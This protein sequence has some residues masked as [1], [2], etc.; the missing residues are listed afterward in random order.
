[1]IRKSLTWNV[2][3]VCSMIQ[4]GS[5]TFDNP[6]QRAGE[7]WSEENK[8]LLIHSLVNMFVPEIYALQVKSDSGNTYDIID[9]KQRL[10]IISSFIKDEWTL[11]E[12]P[13]IK[14]ETGECFDISNKKFS[15]LPEEIQDEIKGFSLSFKIIEL[16]ED[17]DE[18]NL[19]DDIFLRLNNGKPMSK[20]HLTLIS[21]PKNIQEFVRT[22]IKNNP[23]FNGVSSF[24]TNAIKKSDREM[25]IL[26]SVLISCNKPFKSFS[27]KDVTEFFKDNIV[28]EETLD[29]V[30]SAFIEIAEAFEH[31]PSKFCN[32]INI[33]SLVSLLNHCGGS[34]DCTEKVQKFIKFYSN[35]SKPA[36][37]YRK[38]CGAGSVKKENV[39][40]RIKGLIN[41]MEEYKNEK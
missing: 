21:M 35:N 3:Q 13:K 20:E 38:H 34:A 6:V 36:D 10:T 32:K 26:Q 28:E 1:M 17:D 24:T 9:G 29:R 40:N 23:L 39:I 41:M 33:P 2:K 11:T 5:I 12:T 30:T 22:Q 18:E 4:K 16:E 19:V 7:Q 25:A 15:E 27:S 37:Q 31:T 8:S 14:L